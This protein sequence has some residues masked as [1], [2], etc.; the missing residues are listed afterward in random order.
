MRAMRAGLL[1]LAAGQLLTGGWA[2]AA[3]DHFYGSFPGLRT[4]W[5]AADG[6]FNHHLVV[7]AGAGFAATG[8]ALLLA[9]IWPRRHVL[10]VALGAYL[11]HAVPHVAYH[12]R[13]PAPA[14]GALDQV[15]SVV[16]LAVGAALATTLLVPT[17]RESLPRR[18]AGRASLPSPAESAPD[19][20]ESAPG[21]SGSPPDPPDPAGPPAPHGMVEAIDGRPRNLLLKLAFAAARRRVGTVPTS[22]RVLAR[23]PRAALAR[24]VADAAHDGTRLVP[25]RAG[26]L[27]MLRAA[28]LVGCAFCIDILAASANREGVSAEQIRE[29]ARWRESSVFDQDERLAL[30]LADGMT[31]TPTRVPEKLVAELVSRF[32][33][34][35]AV[36]L[37]AAIGHENARARANRALGVAPQG[38]AAAAS[39]P[40]PGP[41]PR[42][43]ADPSRA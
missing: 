9:A 22:W 38:F 41:A 10:A 21:P 27:A 23:A 18:P 12:A 20:A 36:E 35:G 43:L 42:P 17:V 14:L 25:A 8:V 13:H 6:P 7:D 5:V 4:G 2:L 31:A 40:L 19:R 34:A 26:T 24:V 1:F 29:L 37:S 30:A 15:L 32:G 28:T 33:A 16:P 3:P 39:C 11:V